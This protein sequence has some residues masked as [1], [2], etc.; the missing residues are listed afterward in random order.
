VRVFAVLDTHA[1]LVAHPEG[2][3][4]HVLLFRPRVTEC[5]QSFAPS[6]EARTDS[7]G[8]FLLCWPRRGMS[9]IPTLARRVSR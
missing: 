9:F 8:D 7:D 5:L 6:G 1:K 3:C 4:L 2:G